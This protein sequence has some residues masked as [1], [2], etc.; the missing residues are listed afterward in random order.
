MKT[1]TAYRVL[2]FGGGV[3]EG[4][5]LRTHN[6]ERPFPEEGIRQMIRDADAN[7]ISY[8][9]VTMSD[10]EMEIG[11]VHHGT[12]RNLVFAKIIS[13]PSNPSAASSGHSNSGS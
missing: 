10:G 9:W 5:G 1:R 13:S 2:M 3:L 8:L 4:R 12:R 6:L 7:P 11:K